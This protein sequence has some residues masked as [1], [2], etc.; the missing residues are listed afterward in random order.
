MSALPLEAGTTTTYRKG[1][2]LKDGDYD[3]F[4][5][6]TMKVT[7]SIGKVIMNPWTRVVSLETMVTLKVEPDPNLTEE[8]WLE[9]ALERY[10]G[11]SFRD[12]WLGVWMEFYFG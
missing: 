12:S 4:N 5:L 3:Q 8:F 9:V 10:E 11:T 2:A 6:D 7:N 1:V